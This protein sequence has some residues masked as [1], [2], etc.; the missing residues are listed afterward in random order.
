MAFVSQSPRTVNFQ[1]LGGTLKIGP[2]N[3]NMETTSLNRSPSQNRK[4]PP[5]GSSEDRNLNKTNDTAQITPGKLNVNSHLQI[6]NQFN[7]GPGAYIQPLE[8]VNVGYQKE[9]DDHTSYI[10]KDNGHINQRTQ[11][12][13]FQTQRDSSLATIKETPGPGSYQINDSSFATFKKGSQQKTKN[14][15]MGSPL[16]GGM[17]SGYMNMSIPTIPSRYL[18]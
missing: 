7:V 10:I 4:L 11:Q 1:N 2:G 17:G 16:N 14:S 12:Y 3:Y 6:T 15:G 9:L 13:A 5:F 8:F 18:Q